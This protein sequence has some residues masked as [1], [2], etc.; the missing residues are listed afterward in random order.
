MSLH[1]DL[2]DLADEICELSS[3]KPKEAGLRRAVSTAYYAVFHSII[4]FGLKTMFGTSVSI[5]YYNLYGR[6]VEHTT[7]LK[8]CKNI[9]DLDSA[10]LKHQDKS[11]Q[12]IFVPTEK[13]ERIYGLFP[14][15]SLELSTLARNVPILQEDRHKADYDYSYKLKKT[16]VK[17]SIQTAR[18]SVKAIESLRRSDSVQFV[19]FFLQLIKSTPEQRR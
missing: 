2:L 5:T 13:L 7:L 11:P 8:I 1:N 17:G 10:I 9:A 6:S 14:I 15:I 16:D 12:T 19:V 3:T 18:E 4:D